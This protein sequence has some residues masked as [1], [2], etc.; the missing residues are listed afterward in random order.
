MASVYLVSLSRAKGLVCR[1]NS[2]SPSHLLPAQRQPARLPS[3]RPPLI[4]S[5]PEGLNSENKLTSASHLLRVLKAPSCVK[6]SASASQS[7]RAQRNS[8]RL[9]SQRLRHC[10]L[11]GLAAPVPGFTC[12]TLKTCSLLF[13]TSTS[14][15]LSDVDTCLCL[16]Q[17]CWDR[18]ERER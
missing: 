18:L 1:K 2:T 5:F 11:V 15:S 16:A 7:L 3:Q 9:T 6:I 10:V 8:V 17:Y 13:S 14:P 12:R 4:A